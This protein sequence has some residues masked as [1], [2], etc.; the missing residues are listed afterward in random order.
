MLVSSEDK[1]FRP[2]VFIMVLSIALIGCKP[3]VPKGHTGKLA[4]VSSH[5]PLGSSTSHSESQALPSNL[6]STSHSESQVLPSN[7]TR[8]S[9]TSQTS[10]PSIDTASISQYPPPPP[11]APIPPGQSPPASLLQQIKEHDEKRNAELQDALKSGKPIDHVARITGPAPGQSVAVY[12]YFLAPGQQLPYGEMI[13]GAHD[14]DQNVDEYICVAN[15]IIN[16][17]VIPVPGKLE[18]SHCDAGYGQNYVETPTF[19]IAVRYPSGAQG[20]WDGVGARSQADMLASPKDD[21]GNSL[22]PCSDNYQVQLEGWDRFVASIEQKSLIV[23]HGRQLGYLQGGSCTFEWG[24]NIV[25]DNQ[26]V[27]VFY[28]L[29]PPPKPK[30]APP[31]SPPSPQSTVITFVNNSGMD[32]LIWR[33]EHASAGVPFPCNTQSSVGTLDNGQQ[34]MLSIAF[35]KID[36]LD[37]T[38]TSS[39]S[40]CD[41]VKDYGAY[42]GAGPG[43]NAVV[44]LN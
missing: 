11:V 22:I 40:A 3:A 44:P 18:G 19:G 35:G 17:R 36:Y 10:N 32:L 7:L 27:F 41:N 5:R 38:P 12:W 43:Y 23:S 24:K 14:N 20:Y 26:G 39:S 4:S 6:S 2:L 8:P 31:I 37:F 1:S 9:S 25:T 33:G 28:K 15:M 34:W 16:S 29:P 21:K 30:P 42:Q 13:L